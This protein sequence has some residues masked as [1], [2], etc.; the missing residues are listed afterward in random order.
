VPTVGLLRNVH[1]ILTAYVADYPEQCLFAC[2]METSAKSVPR[3]E[4]ESTR[5]PKRDAEETLDRIH[6]F[7]KER[8]DPAFKSEFEKTLGLRPLGDIP[9]SSR[10]STR[11]LPQLRKG[12]FKD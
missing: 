7:S 2:C 6:R 12:A 8:K 9:I 10:R 11:L 5:H 4:E 1:P 3:T